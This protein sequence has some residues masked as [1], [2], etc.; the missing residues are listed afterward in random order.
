MFY[1]DCIRPITLTKKED[2]E[3]LERLRVEM[4]NETIQSLNKKQDNT[5]CQH[6]ESF[7][8]CLDN[9]QTNG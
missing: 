4:L 8:H 6:A 2:V 5:R 7:H 9:R 1:S 3:E